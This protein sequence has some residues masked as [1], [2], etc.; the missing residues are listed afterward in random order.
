MES[1]YKVQIFE[2]FLPND[3]FWLRPR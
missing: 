2:P 1:R 3:K